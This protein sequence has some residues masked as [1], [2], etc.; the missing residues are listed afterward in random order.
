MIALE[1][2][3]STVYDLP[4]VVSRLHCGKIL[5]VSNATHSN[6]SLVSTEGASSSSIERSRFLRQ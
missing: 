1:A 5:T 6:S 4:G 3:R 2:T